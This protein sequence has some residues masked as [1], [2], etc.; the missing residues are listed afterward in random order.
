MGSRYKNKGMQ[1]VTQGEGGGRAA[2]GDHLALKMATGPEASQGS[3][4]AAGLAHT[5]ELQG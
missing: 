3:Q 4:V 1:M 5:H 2:E